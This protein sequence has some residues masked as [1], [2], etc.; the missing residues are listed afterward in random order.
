[1]RSLNLRP[2]TYQN[3]LPHFAAPWYAAC[4]RNL[5][6]NGM[7][8]TTGWI[9]LL[10]LAIE[11]V[12]LSLLFY[13][14]IRSKTSSQREDAV[15][16][17]RQLL[18]NDTVGLQIRTHRVFG[19][20]ISAIQKIAAAGPETITDSVW[21]QFLEALKVSVDNLMSKEEME[22]LQ[23]RNLT[24]T[25]GTLMEF[26][27]MQMETQKLRRIAIKGVAFVMTGAVLQLLDLSFL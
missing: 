8:L 18:E 22:Q 26:Q 23:Q 4:W 10:G 11:V 16:S 25:A 14:L 15:G 20:T 12:G 27:R 17:F 3:P 13:E 1:M 21:R 24:A 2:L 6:E 9:G 19:S 7:D 5:L